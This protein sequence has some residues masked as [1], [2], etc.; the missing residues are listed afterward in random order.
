MIT[1]NPPC[2]ATILMG[3][4]KNGTARGATIKQIYKRMPNETLT[5]LRRH[6]YVELGYTYKNSRSL[7]IYLIV[8]I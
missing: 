8:A 7:M 6:L 5:T 3:I 2:G 1:T 4:N